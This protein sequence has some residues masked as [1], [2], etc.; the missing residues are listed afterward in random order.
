MLANKALS[1]APSAVPVYVED[2]FSTYLYTGNG[3]TQTITNNIDLS[4]KGGLVWTKGRSNADNH[5]LYDTARGATKYLSSNLTN[6]ES[7][8]SDGLTA[9]TSTGY[10]LGADA[11]T[12]S[13]NA[14]AHTYASWT[15]A[16]QAK[17]FDVVTYTGTG[18]TRTVSHNLGSVPGCIIVKRTDGTGGWYVYHRANTANPETDYLLLNSTA[19][20]ADDNSIWGDTAPTASVFTVADG[21]EVNFNGHSYVA[22][23]F[24][25]DAGGFGA[26]GSDSIISC[27][28]FTTDGSGEATVTLNYEPQWLLLKPSSTTG[29]WLMVD[30][31]RGWNVNAT[32]NIQ[33]LRANLSDAE[34]LGGQL[35]PTSTGFK[36]SQSGALAASQ[37]YIYIAIRRGPMKTPTSA[38]TVFSR[39]KQNSSSPQKT[40]PDAGDLFV[41]FG[42]RSSPTTPAWLWADRLRGL[43]STTGVT[44]LDSSSTAAEATRTTSPYI[45]INTSNERRLTFV[46]SSDN[47]T[48]RF[49]RAPGFFDVVCYKGTGS[50]GATTNHNLGV[51]PEL[52]ITRV[53][54]FTGEDWI[55]TYRDGSSFNAGYLNSTAAFDGVGVGTSTDLSSFTS[56][57]YVRNTSNRR[58]NSSSYNYV[59]YLFASLSGVSKVGSYTG[60][61]SS[62]TINCGFTAGSRFVMIKRTDSTGDWV[63]FDSARGIVS[64]NDPYLELNTTDAEV[65]DKDA[66][67]TDNSGFV[68]NETTGPNVNTNGATYIYFSVA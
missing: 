50:A 54:D 22:Y 14:N 17:F 45:Y 19:A 18:S 21:T 15:F 44:I 60:N 30:T 42:D 64:G 63:V 2:V 28:S 11:A 46:P 48:Y 51:S 6:A 39:E 24:A 7:T 67:D 25:H 3:S 53:R 10:T 62:Q 34:D 43:S 40:L 9:F 1:A 65:T 66:V 37:T 31:M 13:T 36:T 27:G 41:M 49:S 29:N 35:N 55:V 4:T 59:A 23:L 26:S 38:T 57:T 8:R 47:M 56:T 12:E 61:G 16:K 52:V 68:V 58:V 5:G 32:G 20:T 33:R